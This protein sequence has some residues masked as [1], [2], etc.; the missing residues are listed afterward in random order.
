MIKSVFAAAAALSMSAGAAVAGPYVNVETNAGWTGDDYTGATTDI[1]VGYEGTV[2]AAGYYVQAG[3]AVIAVDGVETETQ[4]SGKAGVGVPVTDALGVYGEV[5]FL[6][7]DDEDD[8][9]LGGKLG[10]KY[11]F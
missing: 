5:S 11:S 9:G 4:F 7:A 10:V 6:T 1:H 8:F 3:P 2:G